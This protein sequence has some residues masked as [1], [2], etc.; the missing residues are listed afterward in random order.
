VTRNQLL[1]LD[2]NRNEERFSRKQ[3]KNEKFIQ[4]IPKHVYNNSVSSVL[5]KSPCGKRKELLRRTVARNEFTIA[6]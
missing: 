1:T 3:D 5:L 2:W 4:Y 6:P